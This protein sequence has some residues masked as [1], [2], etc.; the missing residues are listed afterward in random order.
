MDKRSSRGA[1]AGV[2][3]GRDN[4]WRQ[5]KI[6]GYDPLRHPL[7]APDETRRERADARAGDTP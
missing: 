5:V 6:E 7:T 4:G 3:D 1:A 2:A